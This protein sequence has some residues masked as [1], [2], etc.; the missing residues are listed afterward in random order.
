MYETIL[1]YDDVKVE[2]R[3]LQVIRV[4]AQ[5][6]TT[7][8]PT[9]YPMDLLAQAY[10]TEFVA[11]GVDAYV[12]QCRQIQG[13]FSSNIIVDMSVAAHGPIPAAIAALII[14]IIKLVAITVATIAVVSYI[15]GLAERI[16]PT[17]HFYASDGTEFDSLAGYVTYQQ[18]LN[19]TKYVCRYCGS[20]FDTDA[21]RVAHEAECPWRGGVPGQET[22]LDKLSTVLIIGGI[23]VGATMIVPPI[24]KTLTEK[25]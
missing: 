11:Q 22:L 2:K 7:C 13:A 9:A 25:R 14:L 18:N 1:L 12:T 23:I 3:G 21:Q 16:Y 24:I 17:P 19:P 20:V 4:S 10:N 15:G 5:A 8:E 6:I